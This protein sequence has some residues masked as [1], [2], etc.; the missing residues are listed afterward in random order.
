MDS[1]NYGGTASDH[2]NRLLLNKDF[3]DNSSSI[4][5]DVYYDQ[6]QEQ[7]NGHQEHHPEKGNLAVDSSRFAPA[8]I[9][10]MDYL[11]ARSWSKTRKRTCCSCSSWLCHVDQE[12]LETILLELKSMGITKNKN[13]SK[14]LPKIVSNQ[15]KGK[16][17]EKMQQCSTNN[18]KTSLGYSDSDTND[19]VPTASGKKRCNELGLIK[20]Y[21]KKKPKKM[22]IKL[23]SL[24]ELVDRKGSYICKECNEVFDDYHALGGH[25][26]AHNR[27]KILENAP[28]GELGTGRGGKR[29]DTSLAEPAVDDRGNKYVC[30]LCSRRFSTG[31]ALGGHKSY[32]R[33][34]ARVEAQKGSGEVTS[35]V[36]N[37]SKIDLNAPPR[38]DV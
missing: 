22:D 9:N 3:L 29:R 23:K 21:V 7:Y 36:E 15:D 28:L 6:D 17:E 13:I 32:H 24:S 1:S 5:T 20:K 18:N 10:L 16:V 12:I 14:I 19:Q 37:V 25:T 27:N 35:S 31:Q 11:P 34:M 2:K 26:A 8:I 33:K 4:A 30:N 38:R